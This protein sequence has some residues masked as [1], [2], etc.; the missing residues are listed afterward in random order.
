MN[1]PSFVYVTYIQSTPEKVFNALIDPEMTRDYWAQHRNASDW[2]PGS[3]WR[4]ER[5][6]DPNHVDIVG[7][8]IEND[9]PR[10]L[11]V[12]WADPQHAG[13]PEKTSRVTYSV[14]QYRDAVRL[15]V[16]HEELEPGSAML[17]GISQGWPAVLSGLKTLLETGES[18]PMMKRCWKDGQ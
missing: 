15:T 11:V 12:T 7:E 14:E 3:P 18:M 9:P 8:V 13:D 4:H 10:R 17:R 2:K 6:D 1:K 5:Y 16:T